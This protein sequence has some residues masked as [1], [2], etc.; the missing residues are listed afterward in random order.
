MT[1]KLRP[2]KKAALA[3][4]DFLGDGLGTYVF[5]TYD[6]TAD[7]R[8]NARQYIGTFEEHEA[9]LIAANLDAYAVH[10]TINDTDGKRRLGSNVVRVRKQFVEID[11]TMTLDAIQALAADRDLP[12][13]WINESSPGK[14]HVYFNVADDV[15][16]DVAGFTVRQ[17]KLAKL[18]DGGRESVDLARLAA[19]LVDRADL[20]GEKETDGSVCRFGILQGK[21]PRGLFQNEKPVFLNELLRDFLQPL[22]VSEVT[23]A[24]N[25]DSLEPGPAEV[26][27]EVRLPARR[28]REP[29]MDVQVGYEPHAG[30]F[31]KMVL[32]SSLA[33]SRTSLYLM[34]S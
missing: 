26:A 10:V 11:G 33:P 30:F 12:I 17:K 5:Q 31:V 28:P 15:A 20:H 14:F 2:N 29:G 25:V 9:A 3:F 16:A 19:L 8:P 23:R 21:I 4:L 18:F 1:A 27:F 6:D 32:S 13:A 24:D 22:G 34:S 7:K